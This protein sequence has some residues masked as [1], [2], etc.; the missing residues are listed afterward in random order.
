[1]V[2]L[3]KAG[4]I[5]ALLEGLAYIIG[6]VVMGTLLNPGNT[7]GWSAAQ[8]LAFVLERKGFFEAWVL[9]VYVGG[10]LLLVVLTAALHERLKAKS[11]E[12]MKVATPFGFIWA[13]HVLASGLVE[14][15]GLNA[16]AK[17]HAQNPEQAVTVWKALGPI[18]NGLG[19][20]IEIVGGVWMLLISV[21]G[22]RSSQLSRALGYLGLG[23]GVAGVLSVVTPL[24]EGA[25]MAFGISQIVWFLWIGI[26]MWRRPASG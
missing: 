1:M 8:R 9:F 21:V 19:G 5:A 11:A 26:H 24:R 4:G 25:T 14:S 3:Q 15:A 10:G 7:Q 6:F 16:L 20:Y 12:L 23:V 17:L 18:Q 2:S 22:L 13:G